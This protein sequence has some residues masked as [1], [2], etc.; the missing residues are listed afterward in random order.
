[1]KLYFIILSLLINSFL[2]YIIHGFTKNEEMI[3]LNI[4]SNTMY[5]LSTNSK[6]ERDIVGLQ[7][8]IPIY[9]ETVDNP[10]QLYMIYLDFPDF[11]YQMSGYYNCDKYFM[12][13]NSTFVFQNNP[14]LSTCIGFISNRTIEYIKILATD[15][16]NNNNNKNNKDSLSISDYLKIIA[17][18]FIL[19][20]ITFIIIYIKYNRICL[21]CYQ[22]RNQQLL[23]QNIQVQA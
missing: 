10:I 2:S 16:E 23:P 5:Y 4:E 8:K 12:T 19:F 18:I 3:I 22:N 7:I 20:G 14:R 9:N 17:I 13:L 21:C 11:T 15:I 1:M 6:Y